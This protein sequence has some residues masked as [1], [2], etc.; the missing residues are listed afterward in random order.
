MKHTTI[1]RVFFA[2]LMLFFS[3]LLCAQKNV[4][5]LMADD[6]N[7][8][9]GTNTYYPYPVSQTL[10]IDSLAAQGVY[11][12]DAN[13]S[14]PVCNPSRNALWSGFRPTTSGITTNQGGFIRDQDGF[15]NIVTMHQYFMQNGYYTI[16]A[17]KL[18][19]ATQMGAYDTDSAN[20][21][22]I[23]DLPTGSPGGTDISWR[24]SITG[25]DVPSW[26]GGTFDIN[27]AED[28]KLAQ[29]IAQEITNYNQGDKPFFI[30][31][32]FFR[33]HLP[34]NSHIQFWNRYDT[35]NIKPLLGY[36]EEDLSDI[37]GARP[38]NYHSD[39]I[40]EGKWKEAMWA[41][42][43][44][45]S[46]ADYNIGIVLD[47]LN[48]SPFKDS[49]IV[50]I[51][52]DHGW[53]L[54]EKE[55]WGKGT[56]YD[57]ANRTMLIISDPNAEGNGSTCPKPVSLQDIYPTL[58]DITGLPN[59]WDVEGNSLKQLLNNPNIDNWDKPIL[60]YAKSSPIIK[61][62]E[63]RLVK[64]GEALGTARPQ[65][66]NI[67]NDPYD[68]NNLYKLPAYADTI[69]MLESMI[70]SIIQK[71]L[72]LKDSIVNGITKTSNKT[73]KPKITF[74]NNT[75]VTDYTLY[76]NL[77][78]TDVIADI[79]IFNL[80]G[81]LMLSKSVPG[82]QNVNLTLPNYLRSGLYFIRIN[83]NNKLLGIEK[84]IIEK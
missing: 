71:G 20:W 54:G 67:I 1:Q 84:F 48:T 12:S 80:N 24:S 60:M 31:C 4:L 18:Y 66:Y 49:T 62:N 37:Q 41:Y 27:T 57:Q 6:F 83:S 65:L 25:N 63:W 11:F 68:F 40:S 15:E 47:A 8:W 16:G 33:P 55:Q 22:K 28:T 73:V 19:H 30:A 50:V 59:K 58:I 75:I 72:N 9:T 29:T 14:F 10:N 69:I 82:E 77:L 56:E 7:R 32:G 34:W 74:L 26:S 17:G 42:M 3:F 45:C 21:D 46:Y 38:S 2:L 43:A 23:I 79:A 81:K 78:T 52:G 39:I 5:L 70:D 64:G 76:L 44:A 35:A 53:H 13:S 51:C 36:K 61:T